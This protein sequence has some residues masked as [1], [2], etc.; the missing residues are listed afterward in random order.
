MKT[1]FP[2]ALPYPAGTLYFT[3][4]APRLRGNGNA[5]PAGRASPNSERVLYE[6]PLANATPYGERVYGSPPTL[7]GSRTY[8]YPLRIY[9]VYDGNRL[10]GGLPHL[11]PSASCLIFKTVVNCVY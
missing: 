4:A 1:V 7:T 2:F 6:K 11:L 10:S 5:Y 8:F 9:R 3:E